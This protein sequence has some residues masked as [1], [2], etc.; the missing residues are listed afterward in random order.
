MI[1]ADKENRFFWGRRYLAQVI[2]RPIPK[3]IWPNK[4]EDFGVPELLRNAGVAGEGLAPIMGWSAVTGAAAAMVADLWVEFSWLSIPVMGAIGYAYGAVWRRA[5]IVGGVWTTQYII[6]ALLSIY[7]ITQSGEAVIFRFVILTLP[8]RY[9]WRK[10]EIV[11]K[12]A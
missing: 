12:T 10:A 7:L 3:Q 8:A 5:V 9:V 1:A 11:Q 2:V 6:F 4:Y